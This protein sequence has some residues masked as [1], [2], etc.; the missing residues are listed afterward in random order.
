MSAIAV[1]ELTVDAP[2]TEAWGRFIDFACWDLWMPPDFRPICGPARALAAGDT[3]T[4]GIGHK[5]RLKVPLDVIRLRPTKEICWRGG[6]PLVVRGEH[7]FLFADADAGKTRIR[8]EET[9]QGLLS[10]GP[11]AA[12]LERAASDAAGDLLERFA[13]YLKHHR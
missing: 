11:F 7:S 12:R 2:R 3:M 5:A 13:E 9:F 8:S 4:V 10:M 1:A 6:N